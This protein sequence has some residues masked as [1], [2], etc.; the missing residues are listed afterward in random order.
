M[1]CKA[2]RLFNLMALAS[3]WAGLVIDER[4]VVPSFGL[5]SA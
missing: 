5:G 1:Y 2:Y 4:A 3:E